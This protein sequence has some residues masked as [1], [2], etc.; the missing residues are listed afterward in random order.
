MLKCGDGSFTIT[1]T[2]LAAHVEAN[3][4]PD[5]IMGGNDQLG[6]AGLKVVS[7]HGR[8]VAADVLVTGFN[9]FEF[10]RYTDPVLTTVHS[11]AYEIGARGGTEIVERLKHGAF[12]EREIVYPVELRVGTSTVRP[13]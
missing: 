4:F 8:K 7:A 11:P 13:G 1:E 6:I 9:A 3:G 12:S 5:A 2:I 10:W